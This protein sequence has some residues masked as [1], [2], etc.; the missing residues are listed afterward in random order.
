MLHNATI[1]FVE[2]QQLNHRKQQV[3]NYEVQ[4]LHCNTKDRNRNP[5]DYN[6]CDR[7]YYLETIVYVL[8]QF[9]M[10]AQGHEYKEILYIL[11]IPLP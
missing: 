8:V 5:V 6:V 7:E 11:N 9:P 1:S 10:G 4:Y 3:Y 2:N